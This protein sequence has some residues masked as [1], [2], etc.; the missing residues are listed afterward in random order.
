MLAIAMRD[1]CR[2]Y[3]KR[4]LLFAVI[5]ADV[6]GCGGCECMRLRR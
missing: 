2:S 4:F 5:G 1:R 3:V 6:R